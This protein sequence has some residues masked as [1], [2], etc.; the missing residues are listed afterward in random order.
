MPEREVISTEHPHIV[1]VPGICGGEPI[2]EGTRISVEFIARLHPKG[3]EP[4]A[5]IASYP[6]LK[7]AAVYD[8]ISYYLDHL[9][10]I[11]RV[12]EEDTL[13]AVMDRYG[14]EIGEKGRLVPSCHST[15]ATFFASRPNGSSRAVS[16]KGL[17]SLTVSTPER[18]LASGAGLSSHCSTGRQ[19]SNFVT[20]LMFS[21]TTDESPTADFGRGRLTV[22]SSRW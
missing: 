11:N 20:P 6:H 13:E 10:E 9:D 21:T 17:L 3:E 2:I 1:R 5:I 18:N 16:M 8:A 14:F 7:P 15:S 22:G 4:W 19:R 12:I